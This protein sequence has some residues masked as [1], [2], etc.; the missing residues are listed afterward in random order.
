MI[1]GSWMVYCWQGKDILT[2]NN[3][4]LHLQLTLKSKKV[5][6]CWCPCYCCPCS[7]WSPVETLE[8]H[9]M[10]RSWSM[11]DWPFPDPLPTL[12]ERATIPLACW[13]DTVQSTGP[14]PAMCRSAPVECYFWHES[15]QRWMLTSFPAPGMNPSSWNQCFQ[16]QFR[17]EF[18]WAPSN[19]Y[20]NEIKDYQ[21][22][23]IQLSFCK[24]TDILFELSRD[25]KVFGL[26]QFLS[27]VSSFPG[28]MKQRK[29]LE[30]T[31]GGELAFGRPLK[32]VIT[33]SFHWWEK[34]NP[35]T[36]TWEMAKSL[37]E[38][39]KDVSICNQETT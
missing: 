11:M 10:P 33:K 5:H 15:G 13:R 32:W 23:E 22:T 27:Q 25:W 6:N 4:K 1:G 35:L 17:I 2:F 26:N 29:G 39:S 38:V 30:F 3:K 31:Q 28:E 14:G 37:D 8:H 16:F 19:L 18:H 20:L 21:T 9:E 24:H 36:I 7:Q 12:A 34:K